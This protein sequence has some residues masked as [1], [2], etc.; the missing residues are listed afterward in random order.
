ML[1]VPRN[2]GPLA[3]FGAW[4]VPWRP[5]FRVRSAS[6]MLL[7]AHRKDVIGRHV[8]KCGEHE[9]ALTRWIDATLRTARRAPPQ[10]R[11]SMSSLRIVQISCVA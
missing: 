4:L 9:P 6:R 10:F 2:G 7:F 8:A 3:Y 11:R 1:R 5:V